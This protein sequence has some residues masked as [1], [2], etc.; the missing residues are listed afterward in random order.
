M[1]DTV[2]APVSSSGAPQELSPRRLALRRF[3][4]HR[5]AVVG[6]VVLLVVV[7]A[8]VVG[9]LLLP[10]D[11]N[12]VDPSAIRQP[13]TP[14]TSSAPTPPVATCSRVCSPVGGS[15]CWSDSRSP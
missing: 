1:T 8:A 5:L 12:A 4:R 6:A 3:L 11:P 14:N 13:R 2:A 10:F 7:L 15:R 9:P